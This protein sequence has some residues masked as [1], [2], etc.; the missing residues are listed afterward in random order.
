MRLVWAQSM[1]LVSTTHHPTQCFIVI[2]LTR[3][4]WSDLGVYW[5]KR[6]GVRWEEGVKIDGNI[7]INKGGRRRRKAGG[8]GGGREDDDDDDGDDAR[9]TRYDATVT[10]R[11]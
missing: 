5:Q 7:T 9:L 8:G 6:G 10:Q 4:I 11:R 2:F 3:T 1:G